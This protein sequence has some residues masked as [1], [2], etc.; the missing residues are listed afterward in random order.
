MPA[1]GVRVERTIFVDNKLKK[2]Y[3]QYAGYSELL[4]EKAG[5]AY[6]DFFDQLFLMIW[7]APDGI[8]KMSNRDIGQYLGYAVSTIEKRKRALERH[9]LIL[10]K[11][12]RVYD[13]KQDRWTSAQELTLDP[14]LV[15]MMLKGLGLLPKS[16]ASST[17]AEPKE[18]EEPKIIYPVEEEA[19]ELPQFVYKKT[20]R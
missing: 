17:V 9:G 20:R 13:N 6:Q 12:N 11:V 18:E 16:I 5:E 2:I 1:E 10:R 14:N 15:A 4:E 19:E 3:K 7:T 8:L